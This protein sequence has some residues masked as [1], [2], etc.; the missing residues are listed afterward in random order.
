MTRFKAAVAPISCIYCLLRSCSFESQNSRNRHIG[1]VQAYAR[2]RIKRQTSLA[3]A[4]SRA[5]VNLCRK[6]QR[7]AATVTVAGHGRDDR[8]FGH[9]SGDSDERKRPD[10]RCSSISLR[11]FMQ[12]ALYVIILRSDSVRVFCSEYRNRTVIHVVGLPTPTTLSQQLFTHR[13]TFGCQ[14]RPPTKACRSHVLW[15]AG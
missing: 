3:S 1:R 5:W 8:L 2:C 6:P 13:H 9:S 4:S 10:N 7:D 12:V 15:H 11:L 14:H